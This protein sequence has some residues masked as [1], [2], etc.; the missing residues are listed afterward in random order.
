[1]P[2][3]PTDETIDDRLPTNSF[4][5]IR[6]IDRQNPPEGIR[7]GESL[8]DAHRR[9][10]A[11]EVIDQLVAWM[12]VELEIQADQQDA[13]QLSEAIHASLQAG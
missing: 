8:E 13:T 12:N 4:D 9:A 1:M 7:R 5:L 10:G 11:R 3:V 6:L 2:A